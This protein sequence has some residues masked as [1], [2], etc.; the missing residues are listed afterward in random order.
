MPTRYQSAIL[1]LCHFAVGLSIETAARSAEAAERQPPNFVLI[2]VDDLGWMDLGCQGSKFYETPNIDRLARQ[3][4]RFT[5]AYAACAVCSPT[6]AA[7]QTGRYPARL[8]ITDWIRMWFQT[9]LDAPDGPKPPQY[10]PS[11]TRKLRCPSNRRH[12]ELDEITLA[13]ALKPAGY[14]SCHIGKWHL[15]QEAWYPKQQGYDFNHGGCDLGLPGS[16]FDPYDISGWRNFPYFKQ[17]YSENLKNIPTL[18]PRRKGEYLTDREADEAVGFIRAHKDQ[19]FFLNISHYAVH[20]PIEAKPELIA[21]YEARPK[22]NRDNP[23]YAAMIHSVDEAT[24]RILATLDELDLAKRT[25]VLFTSD[26]GGWLPATDNTPLRA[27]K[28]HPY[29]GGIRVPLVVRWP[30]AVP[31]GSMSNVPVSSIDFFPTVLDIAGISLPAA[32]TIDGLSLVPVLKQSGGLRR[33]ALYWH[34]PHYCSGKGESAA[35]YSIIRAGGWKLIRHYEGSRLEL[36][37]LAEDLG[38]KRDLTAKMPEKARQLNGQLS[39]WLKSVGAKLPKP[40]GVSK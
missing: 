37:N 15:G 35:P 14:V 12:L 32:R 16:Y 20:S 40:Q 18:P 1:A 3:G 17:L 34:Y 25:V 19:P 21:K 7:V 5:D 10:E 24:G 22:D 38:E 23:V 26:N 30:G 6:R 36:F 27:G 13:E 9:G 4:M 28:A 29:E 33:D 31:P 11:T 2:L 39:A 8:G